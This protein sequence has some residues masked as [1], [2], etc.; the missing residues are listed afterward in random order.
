MSNYVWFDEKGMIV[1]CDTDAYYI[2]I[3][4]EDGLNQFPRHCREEG[5]VE[6]ITE[7]LQNTN[8]FPLLPAM[9]MTWVC[10]MCQQIFL[11]KLPNILLKKQKKMT[12]KMVGL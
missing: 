8:H 11:I 1:D 2:V 5:F 12:R 4:D 6:D 10:G 7:N 3:R 9:T